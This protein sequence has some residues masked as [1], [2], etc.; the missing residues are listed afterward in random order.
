MLTADDV[1]AIPLC[2]TLSGTDLERLAATAADVC[3]GPG[4]FAVHEGGEPAMM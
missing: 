1:R 4:E 2:S 3:L